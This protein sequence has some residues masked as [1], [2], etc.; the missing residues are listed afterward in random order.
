MKLVDI[1]A[2]DLKE[3]PDCYRG[4][5]TDAVAQ[6]SGG[7]LNSL[8]NG[9]KA[10][11]AQRM[12]T[13]W[14]SIQWSLTGIVFEEAEDSRTAIVTRAQWQTAVDAL[15]AGEQAW[16]GEGLPPVG[17]VCE[18][19]WHGAWSEGTVVALVD[20]GLDC[21]EAIIQLNGDWAFA[22]NPGLFRPI[23]TAE[24]IAADDQSAQI[25]RMINESLEGVAGVTIAQA[26]TICSQLHKAGYRKQV[27]P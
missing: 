12:G 14:S 3:W 17:T 21:E 2:R 5:E 6:D 20:G 27:Q 1:L 11:V 8:D 22:K 9:R 19:N 13:Y 24:Q 26:R 7:E 23:R 10:D 25:N 18:Y 16:N 15:K 4:G